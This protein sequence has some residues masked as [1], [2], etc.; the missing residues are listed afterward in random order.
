MCRAAQTLSAD[1]GNEHPFMLPNTHNSQIW[2]QNYAYTNIIFR[3]A[4]HHKQKHK[5]KLQRR[6]ELTT[7]VHERECR[8]PRQLL[9]VT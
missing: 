7:D 2:P 5:G 8:L 4:V 3:N 6:M 1:L 9:R